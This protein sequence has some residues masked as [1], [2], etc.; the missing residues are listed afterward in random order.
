MTVDQGAFAALP[1]TVDSYNSA[2]TPATMATSAKL[3]TY[4]R[5]SKPG[6]SKCNST[7]SITPGQCSRSRA[8]PMEPPMISP[9][10]AAVRRDAV[11]DSQTHNNATAATLKANKA[12]SPIGPCCGKSP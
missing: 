3:N 10:D 12:H 8:L 7:K 2:T 1:P 11:R 5:N 9:S 4:Q 6:V